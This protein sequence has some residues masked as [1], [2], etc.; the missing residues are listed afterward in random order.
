MCANPK[1]TNSPRNTRNECSTYSMKIRLDS[2]QNYILITSAPGTNGR[3]PMIFFMLQTLNFLF[4]KWLSIILIEIG[5][6]MLKYD[7]YFKRQHF[8]WIYKFINYKTIHLHFV[9]QKPIACI[10]N[11]KYIVI[12]ISLLSSQLTKYVLY[13]VVCFYNWSLLKSPF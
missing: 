1:L 8:Q 9:L 2:S 7:F 5:Q 4:W 10:F 12:F 11:C 3:R 13:N 6:N